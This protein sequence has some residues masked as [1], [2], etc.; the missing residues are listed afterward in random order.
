MITLLITFSMLPEE[1]ATIA[2]DRAISA[3]RSLKQYK[4]QHVYES[5]LTGPSLAVKSKWAVINPSKAQVTIQE[6]RVKGRDSTERRYT[7]SGTNLI[8]SDLKT[9]E[10]LERQMPYGALLTERM[11]SGN[12]PP[13]QDRR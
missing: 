12:F 1:P 6:P 8:G 13:P 2:F 9:Q 10:F 3:I 4:L 7:L 11:M 5:N